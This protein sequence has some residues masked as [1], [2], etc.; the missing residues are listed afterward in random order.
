M[1]DLGSVGL[2]VGMEPID[3]PLRELA[4][5]LELDYTV[6]G[7]ITDDASDPCARI[8]R[9]YDRGTGCLIGETTSASVDGAY[10]IAAPADEVQ[11]VALDDDAGTLYNDLI[12]RVIPG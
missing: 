4:A 8:V 5:S 6:S 2:D 7:T 10:S 11:R 3:L 9:L 1:A 12:D